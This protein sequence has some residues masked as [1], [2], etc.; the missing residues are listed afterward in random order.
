MAFQFPLTMS[1]LNR[2]SDALLNPQA[3]VGPAQGQGPGGGGSSP[4]NLTIPQGG[5]AGGQGGQPGAP[6]APK[7]GFQ[8]AKAI[9]DRNAGQMGDD[10]GDLGLGIASSTKKAQEAANK[11]IGETQ[12]K[13]KVD[14]NR[15]SQV[16]DDA[17]A[18]GEVASFLAEPP[19]NVAE[20]DYAPEKTVDSYG[21]E[22][23]GYSTML[24][25]AE[26]L[27]ERNAAAGDPYT[28][29]MAQIDSTLMQSSPLWKQKLMDLTMGVQ[30]Y[31]NT[32]ESEKARTQSAR[33][34]ALAAHEA[35]QADIR[36]QLEGMGQGIMGGIQGRLSEEQ[37]KRQAD[38][39]KLRGDFMGKASG[40]I[41]KQIAGA[42]QKFDDDAAAAL[43]SARADAG[44]YSPDDLRAIEREFANMRTK[45]AQDL[46]S[47]Y[48]AEKYARF[49]A[50][51]LELSDIT[52]DDEARRFAKIMS[53]IDPSRSL[54]RTTPRGVTSSWDPNETQ[55]A[56]DDD[57]AAA[58]GGINPY[59][60]SRRGT[61]G[62]GGGPSPT[63]AGGAKG[64]TDEGLN[65]P[66]GDDWNPSDMDVPDTSGEWKEAAEDVF[67][68]KAHIENTVGGVQ[69]AAK[70]GEAMWPWLK[71][72]VE[73]ITPSAG[74]A[75]AMQGKAPGM[76]AER[77]DPSGVVGKVNDAVVNPAIDKVGQGV[78]WAADAIG[79]AIFGGNN[80][81]SGP[82][83]AAYQK[84]NATSGRIAQLQTA[85]KTWSQAAEQANWEY[86]NPGQ[87]Y[88]D[89]VKRT[90]ANSYISPEYGYQAPE[91]SPSAMGGKGGG[92][93]PA[94]Q[95]ISM[96]NMGSVG[97]GK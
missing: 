94:A 16:P 5:G 75:T 17:E 18:Y 78:D 34:A 14:Y 31:G 27:K 71:E 90:Q 4:A 12:Y 76:V 59:V 41:G 11:Y 8:N 51:E 69:E 39:E 83:N 66:N 50:P 68:P 81:S 36:R 15:V 55:S 1:L 89:Y 2:K 88:D 25:G 93:Q 23:Q 97:G 63:G 37:K 45:L 46:Q 96:G 43:A 20:W 35:E 13:D 19:P 3:A 30:N 9:I 80:E 95:P 57:L 73:T 58:L 52:S 70:V 54:M 53:L 64:K 48:S 26:K 65:D 21:K 32:L 74:E 92:S 6:A 22:L 62:G 84:S 67:S 28:D 72:G 7:T 91:F 47:K 61:W 77:L 49:D 33:E 86:D 42:L 38:V 44:Q 24:G 56:I 10:L 85:G 79:D 40:A 82:G 60:E 29:K 87:S